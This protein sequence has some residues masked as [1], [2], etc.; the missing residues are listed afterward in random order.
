MHRS[1]NAFLSLFLLATASPLL[2]AQAPVR[3][4]AV[5]APRFSLALGYDYI[6]AN[7]PPA[8]CG[9]FNMNGG[10]ASANLP[11]RSWLSADVEVTGGHANN[12]GPL[13]QDLTLMTYTAGPRVTLGKHRV[14]P[15]AQAL[16]GA[17]H[18]GDS[19]FPKNASY[20]TSATSF[21]FTAGGGIDYNL[22]R[23]VAIRLVQ[24]QYLHT[25][26]PNG[27]T[28]SQQHVMLSAGVVF[29]FGGRHAKDRLPPPPPA[30]A[31]ADAVPPAA[32]AAPSSPVQSSA[33]VTAAE[34][35]TQASPQATPPAPVPAAN[36]EASHPGSAIGDIYFD[37]NSAE[38][39]S[40]AQPSLSQ[41]SALLGE[42]A[43]TG[44]LLYG[45]ADSRGSASYNL[46]LGKRRAQSVRKALLHQGVRPERL[47]ITAKGKNDPVCTA[48]DENCWSQNRRV[49][50]VP[51]P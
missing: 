50:L 47:K 38:L 24:A 40:D 20:S 19:Y 9:C 6:R 41:A 42:H 13:G 28:N 10:F 29:K 16:F 43:D 8:D 36:T 23:R 45:Y 33:P 48:Q 21:A 2:P 51:R 39:R 35:P 26:F 12:I 7:A 1:V 14:A 25:S 27:S 34:Q 49:A 3:N 37:Y 18:G 4:D 11:I 32:D 5:G 30:P 17:A 31:T 22:S 15:F 44:L 46:A